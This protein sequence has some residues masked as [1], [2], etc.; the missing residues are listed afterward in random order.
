MVLFITA[1]V[2]KGYLLE[3]IK[4]HNL[5]HTQKQ[6][7]NQNQILKILKSNYLF[8]FT[9]NSCCDMF[10]VSWGNAEHVWLCVLQM[11]GKWLYIGGSSD[12]PGSRSFGHLMTSVWLNI[13]TTS[14]SNVLNLVQT[15]R[16]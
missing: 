15:Q 8:F 13:T 6:K 9:S 5:K 2:Y 12:L 3:L 16:M 7:M 1:V 4:K 11:L 14:Q 10:K